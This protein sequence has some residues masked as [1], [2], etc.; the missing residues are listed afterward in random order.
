[1]LGFRPDRARAF[2]RREFQRSGPDLG[3]KV[4]F[5]CRLVWRLSPYLTRDALRSFIIGTQIIIRKQRL[6][7]IVPVHAYMRARAEAIVSRR[8]HNAHVV[9]RVRS[10]N[11]CPQKRSCI[12]C[13]RNLIYWHGAGTLA[14]L[15]KKE[16][17]R[18]RSEKAMTREGKGGRA[19]RTLRQSMRN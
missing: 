12:T 11:T 13:L 6:A 18:E 10:S 7:F 15:R 1:M 9:A 14:W 4:A 5:S 2:R 8:E 17:E 19:E 3:R 16:M